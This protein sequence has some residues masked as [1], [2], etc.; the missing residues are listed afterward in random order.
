MKKEEISHYQIIRLFLPEYGFLCAVLLL[1]S[2]FCTALSGQQILSLPQA[3]KLGLENNYN[4]QLAKLE[5]ESVQK[6]VEIGVPGEIPSIQLFLD[7]RNRVSVDGSPTSFVDGT[8]AKNEIIGGVD[9]DWVL[10]HG[11]KVRINKTRLD[12]LEELSSGNV[13]LVVENSVHAIILGYYRSLIEYEKL[14]F[15]KEV[16]AFS[17]DKYN[18]ANLKFNYGELS[19][20]ELINFKDAALRDSVSLL[21]QKMVYNETKTQLKTLIGIEKSE[22]L[23]LTDTLTLSDNSYTYHVFK[24]QML[25][26]NQEIRNQLI[27][28]R[29]Q[30]SLVQVAEAE[31]KPKVSLRSGVNQEL[32]S[33]QFTNEN[34]RAL[35]SVFDYYLN[36]TVSYQLFNK[37]DMHLKIQK[38]QMN[39]LYLTK[40]KETLVSLLE[41]QLKINFDKYKDYLSVYRMAKLQEENLIQNL[42]IASFRFE[43][44]ISSYLEVRDIQVRLIETKLKVLEA[45]FELKVAETELIRLTGGI[46]KQ[47]QD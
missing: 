15:R 40:E 2:L 28:I 43:S 24:R 20:F 41:E 31:I 29:L 13:R 6:Q 16:S 35:G 21:E 44:G 9:L 18:D 7:Q 47:H 38:E 14:Q 33:S 19:K 36:F 46:L 10:F 23:T 45:M 37:R 1:S 11:F 34:T 25:S 27:N 5:L 30:E 32:S 8:Y 22:N 17:V 4:I 39:R 26:S 3:V 42:D 12:E